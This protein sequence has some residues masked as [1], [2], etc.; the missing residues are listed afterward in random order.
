MIGNPP[1]LIDC[2]IMSDN[3]IVLQIK[4][5]PLTA[6]SYTHLIPPST[7]PTTP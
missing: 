1:P 3:M 5:K 6:I 7:P 4:I 2:V